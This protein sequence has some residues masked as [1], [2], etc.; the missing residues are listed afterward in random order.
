[1]LV[2]GYWVWSE[3]YSCRG[4]IGTPLRLRM[5]LSRFDCITAR[6]SCAH[7]LRDCLPCAD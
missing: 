7:T 5:Q 6:H 1:M 4:L 3:S 2:N